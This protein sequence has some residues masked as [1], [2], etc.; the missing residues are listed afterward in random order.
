MIDQFDDMG[1]GTPLFCI[2]VEEIEVNVCQMNVLFVEESEA[3]Q[4]V[5]FSIIIKTML[6][7]SAGFTIHI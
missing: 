7:F 5:L 4:L 3:F 2:L 6:L 1:S